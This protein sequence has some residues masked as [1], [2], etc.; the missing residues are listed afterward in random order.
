MY[1]TAVHRNIPCLTSMWFRQSSS[2]IMP[3]SQSSSCG[4]S[5]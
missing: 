1:G 5:A 4:L 3:C 2:A